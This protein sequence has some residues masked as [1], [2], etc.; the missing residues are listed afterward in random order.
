MPIKHH[1]YSGKGIKLQNVDSLMAEYVIRK[2]TRQGIPAL[3]MAASLNNRGALY[4]AQG[5]YAEA[6][7]L[8]QRSLAIREKALGPEPAFGLPWAVATP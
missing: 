4:Q 8:Y 2:P 3:C 7:P 6:E 1:L 5:H